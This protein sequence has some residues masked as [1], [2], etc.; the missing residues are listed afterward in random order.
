M[1][2]G[3]EILPWSIVL[4]SKYYNEVMLLLVGPLGE[5]IKQMKMAPTGTAGDFV[6]AFFY[7]SS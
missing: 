2:L 4:L 7:R 6:V 3:C 1:I 5:M